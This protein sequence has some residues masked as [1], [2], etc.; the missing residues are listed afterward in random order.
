MKHIY[1]IIIYQSLTTDQHNYIDNNL[2]GLEPTT[3]EM[4]ITYL[5]QDSGKSN[6]DA[7]TV[8]LDKLN[9]LQ[10]LKLTTI[11]IPADISPAVLKFYRRKVISDTPNQL[12]N[13]PKQIRY[14]LII[15]FC[16][17]K[18]QELFDNL[19]DHLINFIHKIKKKS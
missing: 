5:K 15:V 8:E 2:L 9:I 1:L 7:I 4:L 11:I 12:K 16:Y 3:E 18:Q 10:G 19:A 6:R 14:A 17:L 13:R